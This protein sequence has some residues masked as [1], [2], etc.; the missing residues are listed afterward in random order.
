MYYILTIVRHSSVTRQGLKWR[1][2]ATNLASKPLTYSLSGLQDV[3]GLESSICVMKRPQRLHSA[4]DGA[5]TESC[6]QTLG[7][8]RG[9]QGGGKG[10]N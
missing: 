5:D 7:R 4:T 1:D 9:V 10:R 3:L 6:S 2:W 8:A